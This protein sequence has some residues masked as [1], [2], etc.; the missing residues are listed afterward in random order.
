MITE[1]E[2]EAKWEARLHLATAAAREEGKKQGLEGYRDVF[3]HYYP[4]R[5]PE[6]LDRHFP[7]AFPYA[8]THAQLSP[9]LH[10]EVPASGV[11]DN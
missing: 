8:R 2:R 9:L 3:I 5:L 10:Y 1:A 11:G 7:D 6:E 4:N